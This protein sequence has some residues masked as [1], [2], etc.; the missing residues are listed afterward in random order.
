MISLLLSSSVDQSPLNVLT[1]ESLKK[2]MLCCQLPINCCLSQGNYYCL[3][4]V[5]AICHLQ[6]LVVGGGDGGVIRE[7]S[8]HPAVESIVQCEIDEVSYP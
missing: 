5:D 8:K 2:K 4:I 1:M 7:V 3:F 6:V